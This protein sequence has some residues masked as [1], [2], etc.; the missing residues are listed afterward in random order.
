M[1]IYASGISWCPVLLLCAGNQSLAETV[2]VDGHEDK[3]VC[4]GTPDLC[5][6]CLKASDLCL[7]LGRSTLECAWTSFL[8]FC[9]RL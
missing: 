6:R 7:M 2:L 3:C 5:D 1:Y 8:E 9:P 4:I